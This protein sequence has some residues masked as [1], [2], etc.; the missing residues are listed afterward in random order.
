MTTVKPSR[1]RPAAAAVGE[2]PVD[3]FQ[4]RRAPRFSPLASVSPSAS[5]TSEK[6]ICASTRAIALDERAANRLAFAAQRAAGDSL[7]LTPLRLGL[8]IDQVGEAL[9]LREID[10]AVHERAPGE[11]PRF[12][13]TQAGKPGQRR[14]TAAIT[15]RPP[16]R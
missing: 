10:L 12:S 2:R 1:S 7:R 3:S 16:V 15:A 9:D 11:F 5:S 14:T 8:R 4:R 6:S 13:R